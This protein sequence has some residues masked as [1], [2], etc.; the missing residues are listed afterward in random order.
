MAGSVKGDFRQDAFPWMIGPLWRACCTAFLFVIIAIAS[1][2]K[3]TKWSEERSAELWQELHAHHYPDRKSGNDDATTAQAAV[4]RDAITV[5]YIDNESIRQ[6]GLTRPL[7]ADYFAQLITDIALTPSK[8]PAAIFIDLQMA[9]AAATGMTG[10]GIVASLD[11]ARVIAGCDTRKGADVSPFRCFVREVAGLTH[12]DQWR[13][14]TACDA[15]AVARMACIRRAG[16][17]PVVFGDARMRSGEAAI[18]DVPSPALDALATVAITAPVDVASA[19]YPMVLGPKGDLGRTHR[20]SLYPAAL[21]YTAW[22]GFEDKPRAGCR[23]RPWTDPDAADGATLAPEF[24]RYWWDE[25]FAE[26]IAIEWGIGP[27]RSSSLASPDRLFRPATC[28]VA[29]GS[30]MATAGHL[31][32]LAVSGIA[33][34][35]EKACVYSRAYPANIFNMQITRDEAEA[36]FGGKLVIIGAQF[37]DLA[38]IHEVPV[39]GGLPGV[40]LHAMATDNLIERG[41][42][43][44]HPSERVT[45]SAQLSWGD[46]FNVPVL[47]TV[48]LITQIARKLMMRQSAPV[49]L[50]G[51]VRR[52]LLVAASIV[53]IVIVVQAFAWINAR[54]WSAGDASGRII[55]AHFNLVG[56]LMIGLLGVGEIVWAGLEP[57][58]E[59]VAGALR[60]ALM[61]ALNMAPVAEGGPDR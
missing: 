51:F 11:Y 46:L 15:N 2:F 50:R 34:S 24:H 26:P 54:I 3:V 5:L 17:V 49:W 4:G 14:N 40:Y 18:E 56:V 23:H 20:F 10:A 25:R 22:C 7:S 58:S 8:P 27:Q 45:A 35:D 36:L 29:D 32:R 21:L 60:R 6:D 9:D 55:P 31:G 59:R 53:A 33:A 39:F 13:G 30:L 28:T 57:L 16:G 61:R 48:A 38:D 41:A 12:Y 1:P 37:S 52:A 42:A 47:F 19:D 44:G 43:Y